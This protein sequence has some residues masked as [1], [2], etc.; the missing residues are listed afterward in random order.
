[1][2]I[3]KR[4][5]TT[6][7]RNGSLGDVLKARRGRGNCILLDVSGSMGCMCSNGESRFN[8]L[9]RVREGLGDERTFVFSN[10]TQELEPGEAI[11]FLASGTNMAGAF[12][13]IKEQGI[14]HV[15]LVSD[16]EPNDREVALREAQGLRIDI[17]YVGDPPAP[18]FLADLANATGGKC[19]ETDIAEV[20]E[21][22]EAIKGLLEA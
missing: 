10:Y 13:C 22:T 11:P 5:E 8:N 2:S 6:P 9:C 4:E 20:K 16:G 3:V 15:V 21:L 14:R 7:M 18:D 17:F 19:G 1:M 12:H